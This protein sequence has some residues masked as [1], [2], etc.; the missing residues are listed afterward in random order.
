[1]PSPIFLALVVALVATLVLSACSS[2]DSTTAAPTPIAT[3][4]SNDGGSVET[5]EPGGNGGGASQSFSDT[6]DLFILSKGDES[7]PLTLNS[8]D[9]VRVSYKATGA[10]TGGPDSGRPDTGQAVAAGIILIVTDPFG[11]NMLVVDEMVE[12]EVEF[13]ADLAGNYSL[14]FFNDF[15]LIAQGV[16]IDY[17]VNP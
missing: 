10:S 14:V 3:V 13:T 7:V 8:G 2:D 12:N 5:P 16:D 15:F 6:T 9:V 11:E 1:M 17:S 4:A